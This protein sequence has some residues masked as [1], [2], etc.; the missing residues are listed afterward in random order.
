MT[1]HAETHAN[2]AGIEIRGSRRY[3][4]SVI[5][6]WRSIQQSAPN[7]PDREPD[8]QGSEAFIERA[9]AFR[10]RSYYGGPGRLPIGF[11][12]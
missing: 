7:E 9:K 5:A 2:G 12:A 11:A 4:R 8:P 1:R 3:I 10:D 6:E